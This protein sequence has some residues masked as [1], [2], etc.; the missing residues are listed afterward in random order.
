MLF[1]ACVKFKNL[2]VG[3][4]ETL[5]TRLRSEFVKLA[6]Y[7]LWMTD[8]TSRIQNYIQLELD[9][10]EPTSGQKQLQG[11]ADLGGH[12]SAELDR[13]LLARI[14]ERDPQSCHFADA[15]RET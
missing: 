10:L 4:A 14:D 12:T 5:N 1:G 15:L 7:I 3:F 11:G 13:V 6:F 8:R 2:V 9:P